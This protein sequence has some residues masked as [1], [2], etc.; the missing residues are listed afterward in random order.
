[1]TEDI[2]HQVRLPGSPLVLFVVVV[3]VFETVQ[4]VLQLTV[5]CLCL[6]HAGFA[7]VPTMPK[8]SIA[9]M[10]GAASSVRDRRMG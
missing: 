5:S 6:L 8:L 4:A 3:T 2:G 1:M 10:V 7:G 9:F